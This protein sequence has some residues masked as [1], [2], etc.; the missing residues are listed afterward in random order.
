MQPS[1]LFIVPTD[2]PV[3]EPDTEGHGIQANVNESVATDEPDAGN[4]PA[5]LDTEG[6]ALA[7][8]VNET[9]ASDR[10][11]AADP[12]ESDTEG[13]ALAGNVN[14]TVVTDGPPPNR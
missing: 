13:H 12:T 5:E 1:D 14:E 3:D 4:D 10:D 9:V 2:P 6:H 11:V 7:F 8:N